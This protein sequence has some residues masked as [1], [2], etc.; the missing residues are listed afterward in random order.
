MEKEDSVYENI[1]RP[2]K[3]S[4]MLHVL[5]SFVRYIKQA[6]QR[7]LDEFGGEIPDTLEGLCSLPG[8]GPKMAFLALQVYLCVQFLLFYFNW[9][10]FRWLGIG[11]SFSFFQ[12]MERYSIG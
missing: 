10:L 5:L 8:I 2:L 1:L 4:L 11:Q 7:I 3:T 12:E 9:G 6:A